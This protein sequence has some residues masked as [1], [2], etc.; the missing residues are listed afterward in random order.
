MVMLYTSPP[1]SPREGNAQVII[2]LLSN[3]KKWIFSCTGR[4]SANFIRQV[5]EIISGTCS[6]TQCRR[7]NQE[8]PWKS[9]RSFRKA[10]KGIS[11]CSGTDILLSAWHWCCGTVWCNFQGII[12]T[13]QSFTSLGIL[14]K[15]IHRKKSNA[16][17]RSLE[18]TN[19]KLSYAPVPAY[20][21]TR[22]CQT[23]SR[24][25]LDAPSELWWS[26][27][28]FTPKVGWHAVHET[29]GCAANNEHKNKTW[30]A[31][32]F[33]KHVHLVHWARLGSCVEKKKS[34]IWWY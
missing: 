19:L 28:W 16:K 25:E 13:L 14:S 32:S 20:M 27:N 8:Q 3:T 7:T 1:N 26:P 4:S 15:N 23:G 10:R 21:I 17:K 33:A 30:T 6:M 34:P 18:M 11:W 5:D 9:L 31:A 24:V 2:L 22:V 29:C 12:L